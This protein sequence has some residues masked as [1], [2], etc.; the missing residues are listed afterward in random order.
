M[1]KKCFYYFLIFLLLSV[2]DITVVLAEKIPIPEFYGIY[3]VSNGKLI[4]LKQSERGHVGDTMSGIVGIKRRSEIDIKESKPN[5]IVYEQGVAPSR[6]LL[7]KLIFKRKI[8]AGGQKGNK[9]FPQKWYTANMWIVESSIQLRVAPIEGKKDM[10]RLVP[11]TPLTPGVYVLHKGD[12]QSESTPGAMFALS[13]SSFVYN[14]SINFDL[15]KE[16]KAK[17]EIIFLQPHKKSLIKQDKPKK[18]RPILAKLSESEKKEFNK[19]EAK[20]RYG[21]DLYYQETGQFFLE[22]G[23]FKEAEKEFQNAIKQESIKPWKARS[24]FGLGLAYAYQHK[25]DKAIEEHLIAIN[26]YPR[27]GYYP[28]PE[29][30]YSLASIYALQGKTD[31][32]VQYLE[33]AIDKGYKDFDFIKSDSDLVSIRN[34]HRYAKLIQGK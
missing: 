27:Q 22:K 25:F 9:F 5:V 6:I 23:L 32:S 12:L 2:F 26:L 17:T 18:Q 1:K 21:R 33:G 29:V 15:Y 19:R 4:Q 20:Y 31:L 7:S 3:L 16:K 30:Y 8:L 24:H 13:Q 34:D 11:T 28:L 10:Y 14:F